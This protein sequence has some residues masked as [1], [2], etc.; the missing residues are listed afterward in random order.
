MSH[1]VK[2]ETNRAKKKKN[3]ETGGRTREGKNVS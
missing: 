1:K 2:K 3:V